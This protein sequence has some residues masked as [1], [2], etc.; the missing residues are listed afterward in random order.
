[1][2]DKKTIKE[3]NR[4]ILLAI[5][6]QSSDGIVI[7]KNLNPCFIVGSKEQEIMNSEQMLLLFAGT[8]MT[9]AL[10]SLLLPVTSM[11]P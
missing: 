11:P 8:V 5:V 6:L 9:H 3:K 7:R 2:A 10:F 4:R 1:M